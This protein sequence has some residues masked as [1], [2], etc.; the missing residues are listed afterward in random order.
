MYPP[1]NRR[2]H[3]KRKKILSDARKEADRKRLYADRQLESILGDAKASA[4]KRAEQIRKQ[5]LSGVNIEVKRRSMKF[6]EQLFEDVLRRAMNVIQ[7]RAEEDD[8]RQ[9][10]L[11]H[12]VEA[13]VGLDVPAARINASEKERSMISKDLIR[14]AEQRVNSLT[15]NKLHL[16]L[17]EE[18]A[19][20]KLG[21]V[22]MAEN[23]RTAYDNGI[24][25][26]L[27]RK[28]TEIRQFVFDRLFKE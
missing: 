28:A 27:M 11:T 26:R 3:G 23:K 10:L 20:R 17:S 14:E 25:T 15:G 8:F 4:E 21:V 9:V 12:I 1:W 13:A 6:Q 18:P 24:D 5:I 16:A 22:L 2:L 7:K 19:L